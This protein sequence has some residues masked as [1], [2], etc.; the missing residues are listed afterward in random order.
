VF[1][2]SQVT[3]HELVVKMVQYIILA[4]KCIAPMPLCGCTCSIDTV[5]VEFFEVK[6]A[7]TA[8]TVPNLGFGGNHSQKMT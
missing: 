6:P 2:L 4:R 7:E 1:K 5:I 3:P 8:G